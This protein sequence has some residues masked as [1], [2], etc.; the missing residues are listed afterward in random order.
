MAVLFIWVR[1]YPSVHV[2][3]PLNPALT[4]ARSLERTGTEKTREIRAESL[5]EAHFPAPVPHQDLPSLPIL[6]SL[7]VKVEGT[8][9]LRPSLVPFY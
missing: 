7:H 3:A 9:F 2:S 8:E 4:Q 6:S 1:T 5:L